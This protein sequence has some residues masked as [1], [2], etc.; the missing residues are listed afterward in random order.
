M[1][2]KISVCVAIRNG[3]RFLQQQMASILP[4]LNPDDEVICSDDH[5]TDGSVSILKSFNDDR[6]KITKPVTHHDHVRNFE[7]ALYQC[8]GEYIFLSD[9]DD[10]WAN[11]KVDLVSQNLQRYHLVLSD[12]ILID[13]NNNE[14]A[15]SLFKIQNTRAGLIKNCIK[16]TYTGCCMAFRKTILDKA[17][18][19]PA[20]IR[21][22]DQWLG[23]VAEKYYTVSLLPETLVRYRRHHHN[24]STTGEKSKLSWL[25]QLNSRITLVKNL[26]FR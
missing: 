21:A 7:H 9:H 15:S 19:F 25:D 14:L 16:N 13:E 5:S 11:G 4:Q 22:H 26:S 2:P 24:Y 8:S 10:L 17:L 12:C 1:R 3:E 6:I 20:G 23:L 18:P